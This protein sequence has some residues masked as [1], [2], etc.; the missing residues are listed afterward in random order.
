MANDGLFRDIHGYL[1]AQAR[2][3]AEDIVIEGGILLA[4]LVKRGITT[5]DAQFVVR[6][7]DKDRLRLLRYLIDPALAPGLATAEAIG[8]EVVIRPNWDRIA[9]YY[10][11]TPSGMQELLAKRF[12]KVLDRNWP[13]IAY[14]LSRD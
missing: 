7:D 8:D 4:L 12:R 1:S 9:E 5:R 6:P 11:Q 13:T 3:S 2:E 14:L 10:G